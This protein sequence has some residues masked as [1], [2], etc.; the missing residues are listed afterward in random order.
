MVYLLGRELFDRNTGLLAAALL[1]VF[2]G[3]IYFARIEHF[4]FFVALTVWAYNRW[5]PERRSGYLWLAAASNLL[6]LGFS[7]AA[8]VIA[9]PACFVL[10]AARRDVRGQA[11]LIGSTLAALVAWL[12]FVE[13]RAGLDSVQTRGD[14]VF[15]LFNATDRSV[16]KEAA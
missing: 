12:L 16:F 10:A 2:P 15:L 7:F 4:S 5:L 14:S 9:V 6:G 13:I 3:A 8:P 1:A 11:I